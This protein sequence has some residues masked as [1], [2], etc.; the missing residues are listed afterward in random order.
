[1]IAF[2]RLLSGS[3]PASFYAAVR[4]LGVFI[5]VSE[6]ISLRPADCSI[7]SHPQS[8]ALKMVTQ[9]SNYCKPVNIT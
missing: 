6:I 2:A 9:S 4:D 1:M 8:F 3:E 5:V 7:M